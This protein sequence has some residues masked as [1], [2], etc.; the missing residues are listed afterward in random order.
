MRNME[1]SGGSRDESAVTG[2]YTLVYDPQVEIV[3]KFHW[4]ACSIPSESEYK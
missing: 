4:Y 1:K 2:G 3:L